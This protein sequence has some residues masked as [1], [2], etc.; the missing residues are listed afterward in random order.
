V[1]VLDASVATKLFVAEV[2]SEAAAELVASHPLLL[3]PALIGVEMHSAIAHKTRA[4]EVDRPT[5]ERALALWR[6]FLRLGN[7]QLTP[8]DVLL[9]AAA[10]LAL[11]LD[12]PLVACMYLALAVR[13]DVPLVTADAAFCEAAQEACDARLLA[14]S[15]RE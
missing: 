7:L 1:I 15:G 5:A 13:H 10:E 11:T 14:D 2:G 4:R 6:E 12:Q 8:D 9:P 3:A